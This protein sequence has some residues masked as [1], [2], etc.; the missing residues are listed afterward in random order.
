[1]FKYQNKVKRIPNALKRI[2]FLAFVPKQLCQLHLS[3]VCGPAPT[4]PRCWHRLKRHRPIPVT[5]SGRSLVGP[6]ATWLASA[7]IQSGAVASEPLSGCKNW[8]T[9][10]ANDKCSKFWYFVKRPY[11]QKL[12]LE[13]KYR[14][15]KFQ[16]NWTK[17]KEIIAE[18][19]GLMGSEIHSRVFD[20][21][22]V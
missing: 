22:K 7:P 17:I 16:A 21:D 2:I 4:S 14:L 5:A 15:P 3:P 6:G 8:L 13:L 20:G 9:L 18:K 11:W 19:Q 10:R 12:A 1:M